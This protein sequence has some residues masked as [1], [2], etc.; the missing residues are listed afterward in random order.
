[1]CPNNLKVIDLSQTFSDA[2]A[3]VKPFV[4]LGHLQVFICNAAPNL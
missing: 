2:S 4:K 1:M 3:F